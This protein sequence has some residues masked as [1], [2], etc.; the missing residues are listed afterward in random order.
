M[1]SYSR[2]CPYICVIMTAYVLH[3]NGQPVMNISMHLNTSLW[4]SSISI[5][6]A[7]TFGEFPFHSSVNK[8]S[9][10]VNSA[11]L[12]ATCIC[13]SVSI[14]WIILACHS[15][16]RSFVSSFFCVSIYVT[17]ILLVQAIFGTQKH[18]AYFSEFLKTHLYLGDLG[19]SFGVAVLAYLTFESTQETIEKS[20]RYPKKKK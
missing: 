7:I 10:L 19:L 13:W 4:L 16:T 15:G 8:E 9:R 6:F 17:H 1:P 2:A 14:A 11:F 5:I 3:T 20:F 18:P 12:A